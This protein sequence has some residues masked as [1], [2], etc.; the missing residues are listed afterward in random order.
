MNGKPHF[1]LEAESAFKHA[2]QVGV[3]LTDCHE[4]RPDPNTSAQRSELPRH[5]ITPKSELLPRKVYP[6]S[7]GRVHH[8]QI[9]IKSDQTMSR[10]LFGP[11]RQTEDF[12][13][14]RCTNSPIGTTPTRRVIN[15]FCV[16]RTMRTAM[17]ASR[18]SRSRLRFDSVSSR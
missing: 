16:G 4:A 7:A 10:D 13:I 1:P 14:R 6:G 8:I 5:A 17:S 9:A 15:A 2:Y 11:S 18:R 12:D 3:A